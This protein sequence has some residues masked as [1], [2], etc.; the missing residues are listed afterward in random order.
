MKRVVEGWM[1][2]QR[3][4]LDRWHRTQSFERD[5]P[6]LNRRQLRT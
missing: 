2:D 1:L 3:H 4:S 5:I 6:E